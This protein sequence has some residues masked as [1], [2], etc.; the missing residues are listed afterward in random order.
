MNYEIDNLKR[1]LST[2]KYEVARKVDD[3]SF[4]RKLAD[5]ESNI[6]RKIT[7]LV[8]DNADLRDRLD[9][10]IETIESNNV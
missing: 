7:D 5:L 8:N 9:R 1:E 4:R 3:E 6:N 10:L 2:L